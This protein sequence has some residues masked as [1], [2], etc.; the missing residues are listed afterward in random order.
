MHV[1]LKDY[2][3]LILVYALSFAIKRT[4]TDDSKS[5]AV[6]QM[7]I[8]PDLSK[9]CRLCQIYYCELCILKI[10]EF[11]SILPTQT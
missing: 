4:S 1:F 8:R 11:I 6:G 9:L 5:N 3:T 10:L 7:H 2:C